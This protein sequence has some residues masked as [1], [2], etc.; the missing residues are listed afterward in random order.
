IPIETFRW[1][2]CDLVGLFFLLVGKIT[3]HSHTLPIGDW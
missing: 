1:V 2:K 3:D